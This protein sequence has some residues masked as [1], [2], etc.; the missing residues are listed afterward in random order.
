MIIYTL[1]DLK[2]AH[3][4]KRPSKTCKSP[5]VADIKLDDDGSDDDGSDDKISNDERSDVKMGHA[6]SLGCCG[7]CEKESN[8]LVKKNLNG[9]TCSHTIYLS[10]INDNIIVGIHPKLAENIVDQALQKN[11]F[12]C[13]QNIK[14]LE[15]EKKMLNSRFDFIG[16]TE[17][18]KPFILEV[19]TVP[20]CGYFNNIY[21]KYKDIMEVSK[22]KYPLDKKI[23]YFPDGYRK[24]KGDVV[25]PRALKHVQELAE[26]AK[27]G[28]ITTYLCFVVQ[29][30]DAEM[31]QISLHDPIYRAAVQSAVSDGVKLVVLHIKW[32]KEGEAYFISDSLP[33]DI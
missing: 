23:A 7:L 22:D 32:T 33:I 17:D 28:E 20:L 10:V 25:S 6:P 12:S 9:K 5:Y 21:G 18:D 15:R 14:K 29:R 19:K 11:C 13:L 27:K 30:E 24:K 31:F 26:I 2:S 1:N 8:V 3:I 16:E 4:I